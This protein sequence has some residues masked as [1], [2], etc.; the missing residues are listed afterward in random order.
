MLTLFS[1]RGRPDSGVYQ[2][3]VTDGVTSLS[4]DYNVTVQRQWLFI[5]LTPTSLHYVID[6]EHV[7]RLSYILHGCA[8]C[9]VQ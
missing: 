6:A 3:H 8:P 9:R 1:P 5:E 7:G 2:C 4:R